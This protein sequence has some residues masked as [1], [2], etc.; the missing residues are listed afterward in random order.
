MNRF[1]GL[2]SPA[3]F[4]AVV[5]ILFAAEPPGVTPMRSQDQQYREIAS[6]IKLFGDVYRRVNERYVDTINVK[7]FIKAGIDGMLGTL[8]PYTVYFEADETRQLDDLTQGKYGGIGIEIGLRGRDRELTVISPIEDTPAARKGLRA[9]DVIVAINGKSTAGFNTDDATRQ[10]RGPAG[11]EVVV[12]IRRPGFDKPLEFPLIRQ[13]IPI[14]DVTYVGMI[15]GNVGL[16]RLAHFSSQAGKELH[17]ALA[18]LLKNKPRGLILD[19]RSNPGGLLPSAI[20]VAQE[21]LQ[22][23]DEIVST[24]GRLPESEQNFT[25]FQRTAQDADSK[26]LMPDLPLIV[27]VNGGS[28][29]ASEIVSGAIQDLDRGVILGTQ[30]FGK[31]LVQSVVNLSDGNVLKVTTARYYTPSGR[32][33]QKDRPKNA[34]GQTIFEDEEP[35]PGELVKKESTPKDSTEKYT[36]RSGRSVFGGGGIT[37]DVVIENPLITP[38]EVEFF[39]RDLFFGFMTD[40]LTKHQRPDTVKV[41]EEMVNAFYKYIDSA[42]FEA[43]VPGQDQLNALKKIGEADSL[44]SE[45]FAQIDQVRKSLAKLSSVKSPEV[46]EFIKQNLDRELASTLGGRE[47]RIR[48]SFDEDVQLQKALDLLK[49]RDS[50]SALLKPGMKTAKAG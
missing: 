44:N 30:S 32:L 19:L 14:H 39:R 43:P 46:K 4:L 24:R 1:K 16:I 33:I 13:E 36:T 40:Y 49:N 27:M 25:A 48:S 8:D 6:Q 18:T 38:V 11:T 42:K 15:D 22:P 45:Y 7:D 35:A 2:L 20:Q 9:G 10:I 37:P 47:W 12:T 34:A 23:G 5:G 3:I 21:F 50:Y 31:G 17:E 26:P 29:S 41:S 28:A